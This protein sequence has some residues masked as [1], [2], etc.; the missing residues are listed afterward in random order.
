MK[1]K[2][3]I[4]PVLPALEPILGFTAALQE[5]GT[6][7]A[8]QK[9]PILPF[10]PWQDQLELKCST[11]CLV[12]LL[13]KIN[14]FNYDRMEIL[15]TIPLHFANQNVPCCTLSSVSPFPLGQEDNLPALLNLVPFL[16]YHLFCPDNRHFRI[17]FLPMQLLATHLQQKLIYISGGSNC[18]RKKKRHFIAIV[19]WSYGSYLVSRLR[20]TCPNKISTKDGHRLT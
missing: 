8:Y 15:K 20:A 1:C 19:V 4:L 13:N 16:V 10:W 11:L 9:H 6:Q 2:I 7:V 14:E 3:Q 17:T 5:A 18:K 12:L